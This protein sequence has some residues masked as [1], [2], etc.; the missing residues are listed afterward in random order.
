MTDSTFWNTTFAKAL[1]AYA[2]LAF[3]ILWVG[4]VPVLLIHPDW[5]ESLW[6]WVNGL[7]SL[8]RIAIWV[9]LTPLLTALWIWNAPWSLALRLL[10]FTG[11]AGCGPRWGSRVSC[12][13][14]CKRLRCAQ[15]WKTGEKAAHRAATEDRTS[16][17][18]TPR[19]VLYT[20]RWRFVFH[21]TAPP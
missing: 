15:R 6:I 3:L 11:L 19:D 1:S 17:L 7:P 13:S 9:V 16:L 21:S 8:W 10:G 2:A 18:D 20:T 14:G 5:L 12:V 4:L